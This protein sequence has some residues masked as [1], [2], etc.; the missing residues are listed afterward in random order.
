MHDT[1]LTIWLVIVL[2]FVFYA[3]TVWRVS[4]LLRTK[5]PSVY[6]SLGSPRM[7][8]L[9]D[10]LKLVYPF[11]LLGGYRKY[12]LTDETARVCGVARFAVVLMHMLVLAWFSLPLWP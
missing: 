3:G 1:I 12:E 4:D 9:I 5:N 2:V 7:S 8:D 6:T 11:L 10:A